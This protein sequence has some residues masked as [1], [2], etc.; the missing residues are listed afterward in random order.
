MMKTLCVVG[1]INADLFVQVHRHPQPGETLLGSG[2]DI[3][4]GG[5]GA[6]QAVAAA[7]QG[8]RVRFIGAVGDDAYAESALSLMRSSGVDCSHISQLAQ[9]TTGLAIITVAEDGENTIIVVPGANAAVDGDF[10][11]SHSVSDAEILLLQGE[12][13]AE[14]FAAAVAQ[15]SGRVIINLAPVIDVDRAALL[16]A[17]PLVVNEHEAGLVMT[18]L[19]ITAPQSEPANMVSALLDAGF[20]SVVLTLGA[21]GALLGDSAGLTA[22]PSPSITAVD[23]T[24]AGDAF[25]GALAAQLLAG[26]SLRT[27]AQHA[28]RVGAYAATKHGAQPSYPSLSDPLPEVH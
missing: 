2:G 28:A 4:P 6:N 12:I 13:P 18:Q 19:G 8:A 15:A 11:A 24:G 17:D 1:S 3:L 16:R 21:K 10:L 22:I 5:K 23:T 25:T 20:A 26:H 14:G 27:A 9:T 7:L